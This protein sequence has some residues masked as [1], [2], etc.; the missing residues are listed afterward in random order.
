[1]QLSKRLLGVADMVTA[2]NRLADVGTDHGYIPVYLVKQGRIPRAIAMDVNKGPL[3]R[4]EKNITMHAAAQYIETR[5]SDGVLKLRPGEVDSIIIAGMGGSL[6]IK[7]LT[8]GEAVCK[9]VD[10]IILQPQSDVGKVRHYLREHG[11]QII[12]EDMVLEDGKFYP[13]MKAVPVSVVN[14]QDLLTDSRNILPDDEVIYNR[15]GRCLLEHR[16]PVLRQ[17]LTKEAAVFKKIYENIRFLNSPET[18]AR[19]KEI[20]QEM[21]YIEA[22]QKYYEV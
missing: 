22:A 12:Y 3:K 7:I 20:E 6:V 4:A 8:E 10:E 5:L 18:V 21:Q 15:Y 2:G 19:R 9:S 16:N 17:F 14:G 13:M 1:M 11:Y